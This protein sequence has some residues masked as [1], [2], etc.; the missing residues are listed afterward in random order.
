ML[1]SVASKFWHLYIYIYV[2]LRIRCSFSLSLFAPWF[3]F[4]SPLM[5]RTIRFVLKRK[6]LIPENKTKTFSA[7][8]DNVLH[9]CSLYDEKGQL[10]NGTNVEEMR[11]REMIP[12]IRSHVF[13]PFLTVHIISKIF[14]QIEQQGTNHFPLPLKLWFSRLTIEIEY[15]GFSLSS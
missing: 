12:T 13:L 1:L 10:L 5:R 4:L 9:G 6:R 3:S 11:T 7:W 14:E 2:F 8:S 15:A